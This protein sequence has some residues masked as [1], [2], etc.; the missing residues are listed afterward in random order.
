MSPEGDWQTG[1]LGQKS[2]PPEVAASSGVGTGWDN[3]APLGQSGRQELAML[4]HPLFPWA[5]QGQLG[6]TQTQVP[7]LPPAPRL[8]SASTSRPLPARDKPTT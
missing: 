2:G 3:S 5:D 7:S 4:S 6:F 1:L 8:R